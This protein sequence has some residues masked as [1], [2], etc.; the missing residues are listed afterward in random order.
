MDELTIEE[1]GAREVR[2]LRL[3]GPLTLGTLFEFQN[4]VRDGNPGNL[5]LDLT[6]VPYMDSAGLGSILGAYASCQQ[7][8]HRFALAGLGDRV[9]TILRITRVDDLLPI[10]ST[11][12][13]AQ[14]KI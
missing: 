9:K 10:Y 11:L 8:G 2:V 1:L 6:D 5:I 7:R 4:V 14:Q 12:Q 3:N 13:E